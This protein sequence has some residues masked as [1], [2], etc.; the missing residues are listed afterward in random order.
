MVWKMV[1]QKR[2]ARR[3]IISLQP[4]LTLRVPRWLCCGSFCVKARTDAVKEVAFAVKNLYE[5]DVL[6]EEAIVEWYENGSAGTN[7]GSPVWKHVK[8]LVEWL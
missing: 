3:K 7:K 2:L 5:V 6:E 1:L 8:P 4:W